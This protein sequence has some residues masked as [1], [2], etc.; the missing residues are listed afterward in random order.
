[1]ALKEPP[2]VFTVEVEVERLTEIRLYA[3]AVLLLPVR[4]HV[5]GYQN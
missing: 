1:M 5:L 3:K 4:P 2:F